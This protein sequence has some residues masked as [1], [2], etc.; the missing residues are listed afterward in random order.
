MLPGVV[1][2]EVVLGRSDQAVVLLTGMRAFPIGV[3]MTLHIRTRTRLPE[4]HSEVFDGPYRHGQG[5]E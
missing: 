5:E 2:I 1:P 3:A 4:L